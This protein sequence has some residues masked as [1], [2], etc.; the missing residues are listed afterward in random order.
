MYTLAISICLFPLACAFLEKT[1]RVEPPKSST[2]EYTCYHIEQMYP[3]SSCYGLTPPIIITTLLVQEFDESFFT[4][5]GFY[6]YGD[7][8]IFI[9]TGL[10]YLEARDVI[11]HETVHY[12]LYELYIVDNEEICEQERVARLIAGDPWDD[13]NVREIYGC[14]ADQK[15]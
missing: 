15:E 14:P 7:P 12:V 3:S 1:Y 6:V 4:M 5:E 2:F 8:Y 13:K 9:R 10:E 11:I